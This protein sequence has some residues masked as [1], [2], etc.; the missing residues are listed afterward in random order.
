MVALRV[1]GALNAA[2]VD[3]DVLGEVSVG[4]GVGRDA[5]GL[6][7]GGVAVVGVSGAAHRARTTGRADAGDDAVPHGD[8]RDPAAGRDDGAGLL[9]AEHRR[10]DAPTGRPPV[11]VRRAAPVYRMRTTTCCSPGASKAT[12]SSA[13]GGVAGSGRRSVMARRAVV[14]EKQFYL[15]FERVRQVSIPPS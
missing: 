14:G 11:R 13:D 8:R 7:E 9:V 15:I 12:A 10:G 1:G 2:F 5:V 4:G 6:G 3:G